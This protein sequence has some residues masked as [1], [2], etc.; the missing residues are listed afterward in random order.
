MPGVINI[1]LPTH[2]GL[3]FLTQTGSD[4]S[5]ETFPVDLLFLGKLAKKFFIKIVLPLKMFH[6]IHLPISSLGH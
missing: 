2:S 1:V 5:F 4:L 3:P 6:L